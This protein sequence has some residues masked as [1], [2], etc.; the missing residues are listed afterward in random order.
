VVPVAVDGELS[1]LLVIADTVRAASRQAIADLKALC[2][3]ETVLVSG[4][5]Q[6]VADAVGRTLGVDRVYSDMLPAAKLQLVR[7]LQADGRTVAFVGDGVNDAPALAAADIGVAMGNIGTHVAM[8]T[9]DIVLLSDRLERLPYLVALSR[10]ALRTIRNNVLFAMA[11]NVL[12]VALSVGG[13]IGP[14]LGAVMHEISA[15]PVVANS[16][17]LIRWQPQRPSPPGAI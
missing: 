9:A 8:E 7:E 12:A 13:V 14:V 10:S 3:R 1:G 17:R 15:L 11:M 5:N 16:A 6:A 2:V 4:D